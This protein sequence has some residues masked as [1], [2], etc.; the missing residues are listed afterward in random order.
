MSYQSS[1][2]L[3]QQ[4]MPHYQSSPALSQQS[5]PSTPLIHYQQSP[6]LSQN[7]QQS[8]PSTPYMAHPP[9]AYS[10]PPPNHSSLL[11]QPF[12]TEKYS[13]A[14][15]VQHAPTNEVKKQEAYNFPSNPM[16]MPMQ[17]PMAMP[18]PTKELVK[19]PL[20]KPAESAV[21]KLQQSEAPVSTGPRNPQYVA[22]VYRNPQ[23]LYEGP[24]ASVDTATSSNN[25]YSRAPQAIYVPP[26]NK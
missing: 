22:L 4:S 13:S 11:T 19:S 6:L 17:K 26:P 12:P 10:S 14:A 18:E 15:P 9:P 8:V 21:E 16:T 7:S 23:A 25:A 5:V 24:P 2:S 1:P 20:P 3:S